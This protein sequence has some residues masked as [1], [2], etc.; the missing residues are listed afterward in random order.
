MPGHTG[1]E[2]PFFTWQTTFVFL[3][4]FCFS[5]FMLPV[6]EHHA[7]K[8]CFG[9]RRKEADPTD[10]ELVAVSCAEPK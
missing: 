4:L 6:A 8:S 9:L 3:Q 5:E 10:L 1:C 7:E 2:G